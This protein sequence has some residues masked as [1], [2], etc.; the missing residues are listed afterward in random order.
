[1]NT[2]IAEMMETARQIE[3]MA[4][5]LRSTAESGQLYSAGEDVV[6]DIATVIQEKA[7]ELRQRAEVISGEIES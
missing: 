2:N 5:L 4:F 6:E 1:M 3:N 7:R